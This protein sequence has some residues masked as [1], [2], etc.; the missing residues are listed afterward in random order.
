MA[1]G[2]AYDLALWSY[3]VAFAH[4]A[5]ER[6]VFGEKKGSVAAMGLSLVSIGWMIVGR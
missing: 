1:D 5:G 6:W 2:G 4:F 3:F